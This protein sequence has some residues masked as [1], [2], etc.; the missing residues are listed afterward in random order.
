MRL[1]DQVAVVKIEDETKPCEH[2]I[3]QRTP[4]QVK[5]EQREKK[6]LRSLMSSEGHRTVDDFF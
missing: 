1:T 5:W 3:F 6:S 2:A 4:L